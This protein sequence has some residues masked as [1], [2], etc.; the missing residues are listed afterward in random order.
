MKLVR[1]FDID[2]KYGTCTVRAE[3]TVNSPSWAVG[4]EADQF[5]RE[6]TQKLNDALKAKD[7]S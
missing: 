7:Y 2:T 5:L 4:S 6:T 1:S 3:I